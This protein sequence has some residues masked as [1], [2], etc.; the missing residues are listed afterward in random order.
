M[1]SQTV[2]V[3]HDRRVRWMAEIGDPDGTLRPR[4]LLTLRDGWGIERVVSGGSS[5][6]SR[7]L[8]SLAPGEGQGGSHVGN[9]KAAG[10]ESF[11]APPLSDAIVKKVVLSRSRHRRQDGKRRG[12]AFLPR[13]HK[14]TRRPGR[15]CGRQRS[16]DQKKTETSS[17]VRAVSLSR[18][19]PTVHRGVKVNKCGN[20][21][22]RGLRRRGSRA[23][24]RARNAALL[25][26]RQLTAW[27]ASPDALEECPALGMP[28]AVVVTHVDHQGVTSTRWRV[29]RRSF[30]EAV[31]PVYLRCG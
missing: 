2:D 22:P 27:M 20:T 31:Q 7:H 5:K 28:R 11:D 15:G 17:L 3:P 12:V 8:R 4:V 26:S 14:I 30:G 6:V 10:E 13:G 18:S 21:R 24:L 16:A 19:R 9:A 23:G 29:A 25:L 1:T